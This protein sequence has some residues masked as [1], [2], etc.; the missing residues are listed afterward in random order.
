[1]FE[2]PSITQAGAIRVVSNAN[3]ESGLLSSAR[4]ANER[5]LHKD[6]STE[7]CQA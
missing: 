7:R 1:M 6:V 4:Y 2:A 3:N 5:Y